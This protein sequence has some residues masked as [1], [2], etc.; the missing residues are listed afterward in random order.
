MRPEHWLYTIPLRLRSLLRGAQA[1]QELDEELR[2]HLERKTEEYVAKGRTQEEAYRRARLDLGGIE[3][4]KEKCRET[5]RVNWIQ[6][7]M[8]DLHFGLRMLRKSSGFTAVAIFTLALGIGANTAI[9]S[10]VNGV[11]LNRLP[12][13]LPEQLVSL[14]ETLPPFPEFA[15]SYPNF[16]DWAG[17][18][19]TFQSLAAYRQNNFNLTGWGEAQRVKAAQVS[20]TFFPLL[21]VKPVIGRNLSSDEDKRAGEPVVMLS[22]GFWRSKFGGSPEILDKTL[23]LDGKGYRVVGVVPASFYFCCETTNFRLGDVYLPLGAWDVPWMQ[24]R[25]AHPGLFAVGRL[26]PGVTIEVTRADMD[27]IARDL[28]RA[29]P[30]A[31]KNAGIALTPLKEQMVGD[32]RPML[33]ILQ[34]AVG[35]VLAIACVNVAN[36]LVA[37]SNARAREFALRV[38]LGATR[39]R[40]VR[41][42]LVESVLLAVFGGTLGLLFAIWG[43]HGGVTALREVLPRSSDVGLDPH[44]L[45]FALFVSVLAGLLF[46][47]GPVSQTS[48]VD[49][50]EVLKIGERRAGAGLRHR[51]R[52]AS[53]AVEIALAVVL[54]VGAV[55][56]I[57]S[58]VDLWSINPGFDPQNVLTFNVALPPSTAKEAPNQVRAIVNRL[59]D[60]IAAVPGVRTAAITDG[61]FPMNGDNEVGFWVEGQPKPATEREMPN[62]VNYI[63]SPDY[64]KAMGIPLR[65]GRFL[66][67]QDGLHSSFVTDIDEN[68]ARRYFPNQD[69]VG[70][71]VHLAGLDRPFEIVGVV[72]HVNQAGLDE[73]ENSPMAIQL[74]TAVAQIPDEYIS[75]LARAEGFVVRTKAANHPTAG[76]I[77]QAI[78]KANGEQ[79][80]YDFEPMEGLI[81]DSL[82]RRRFSM[83][84]LCVFAGLSVLLA[85]IGIYGV[86]S[87]VAG[88]RTHEIGIRLALGASRQDV[89]RMILAQ[90]AKVALVGVVLGLCAA[91][92]LT[93]MMRSL[94]FGVT[95]H[96]PLTFT[97][98]PILLL[99]VALAACY[100]PARRATRVDPM[101]AL[102]Y[103]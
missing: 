90:S 11:L 79:V 42:L 45:L 82:G 21:G 39:E 20:A 64:L 7:L 54:L 76:A 18:N 55:L 35:F 43:T 53:V 100:I 72:G 89:L 6:D 13:P 3:Q 26:K 16:L 9:F 52:N 63:V 94:L 49:I 33:L 36:L 60:T 38:A 12:Y 99:T 24:D 30:N 34:V 31:D 61:A 4:T 96:D 70:K 62:A 102:R 25:G 17:M 97:V 67:P 93:Q 81:S 73:N 84:L 85:S 91:L 87:Y 14:A 101:I 92:G 48:R 59:A 40:V 83:I 47:L 22:E 29:Y 68:F 65:R 75:F 56:T 51:I 80:A 86:V 95:A 1:D 15:I 27:A 8:Q 28:A 78:E 23:V 57:R 58:L 66:M 5:R 74:Y 103:E 71:Y 88:R 98:V 44:V 77:R 19:H 69:P 41:Q 46:G 37:R 10:V 2:D 50:Q 32:V